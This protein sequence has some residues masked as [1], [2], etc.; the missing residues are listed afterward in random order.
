M[1]TFPS[2]FEPS[3]PSMHKWFGT[4]KKTMIFGTVELPG[5]FQTHGYS[6]D[7]LKM[8]ILLILEL[9]GAFAIMYEGDFTLYSVVPIFFAIII[10]VYLAVLLHKYVPI[11]LENKNRAKA[12][13][14][15]ILANKFTQL[16]KEGSVFEII[17][18]LS[19]YLL[20]IIKGLGY[21]VFVGGVEPQVVLMFFIYLII[22]NLHINTTGYWVA[23]FSLN[24]SIKKQIKSNILS[25]GKSNP[26]IQRISSFTSDTPI[27][28][29]NIGRH[30]IINGEIPGEYKLKTFGVLTDN[31]L[32]SMVANQSSVPLQ[33]IVA[34]ACIKH[35]IQNILLG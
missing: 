27:Q 17:I 35:Q 30:S 2:D 5:C 29:V 18:K 6:N 26:A 33:S 11:R 3:K 12:T 28:L 7:T 19:I 10:D 9:I 4:R 13:D 23:E 21:F 34:T 16:S 14:D 1:P 31:E 24:H 25:L 15:P 32:A 22:A 8:C 20:A